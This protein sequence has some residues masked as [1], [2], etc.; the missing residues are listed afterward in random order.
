MSNWIRFVKFTC[1]IPNS[2]YQQKE[3]DIICPT[4]STNEPY[5]PNTISE[6]KWSIYLTYLILHYFDKNPAYDEM[7]KRR[8]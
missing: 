4:H 7:L 8:T 1:Q 2:D 3:L 6:P 5:K